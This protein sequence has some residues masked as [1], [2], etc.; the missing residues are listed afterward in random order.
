MPKGVKVDDKH[1]K[2]TYSP[3]RLINSL[4]TAT[5]EGRGLGLKKHPSLGDV[6]ESD[7]MVLQRIVGITVEEFNQRLIGKLDTLADRIVDRMLDTVDDTPLQTLGFNLA[8]AIDKRQRIAGLNATQAANVNI[9]VNNYGSLSKE[10]IVARLS[11]KT[12]V[13]TIQSAPIDIP[14]A[15]DIDAKVLKRTGEVKE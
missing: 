11:G 9:Q 4:A 15:N 3:Q 13:P 6:T 2:T 5:L 10:E 8:V 7:R 14:N 1:G 12:S